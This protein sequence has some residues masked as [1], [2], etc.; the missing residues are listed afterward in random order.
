MV[1]RQGRL[2]DGKP[3]EE[4]RAGFRTAVWR[5]DSHPTAAAE[6]SAWTQQRS[7]REGRNANHGSDPAPP[8]CA[9]GR[10]FRATRARRGSSPAGRVAGQESAR[11]V[12][13]AG[14]LAGLHPRPR[15]R[16]KQPGRHDDLRGP[17]PGAVRPDELQT[18]F[19]P[20][21][22]RRLKPEA[23]RHAGHPTGIGAGPVVRPRPAG[24][25]E[26]AEVLAVPP[27]A[28]LG[29]PAR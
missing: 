9:E 22:R 2:D 17:K 25:V 19:A 8:A 20:R 23:N 28:G 7:H 16:R 11:L 13:E 4:F 29:R 21:R 15:A 1:R 3:A 24:G 6:S 14:R 27:V 12:P 10:R 26:Q 5:T 18:R